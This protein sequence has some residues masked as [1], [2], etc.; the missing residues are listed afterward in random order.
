[1]HLPDA[2]TSIQAVAADGAQRE[3]NKVPAALLV[4]PEFFPAAHHLKLCDLLA[5]ATRLGPLG[6]FLLRP[7]PL[8]AEGFEAISFALA[9]EFLVTFVNN[10]MALLVDL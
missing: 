9:N 10:P 8:L 6:S 4:L 2:H 5:V 3:T 1:M 7:D